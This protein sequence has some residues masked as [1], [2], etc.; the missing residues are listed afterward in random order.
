MEDLTGKIFNGLEVLGFSHKKGKKCYWNL[1]CSCGKLRSPL[2]ADSIKKHT[3]MC[4]CPLEEGLRC[5]KLTYKRHSHTE[6]RRSYCVVVCDCQ[7]EFVTRTDSFK[8][9]RSGCGSC[10]NLYEVVGDEVLLDVST[11]KHPNTFTKIDLQDFDKIKH[12]KWYAVE[13]HCTTYVQASDGKIRIPL[14]R[15]ILGCEDTLVTDHEDGDGLNNTRGNLRQVTR[16]LNNQNLPT[17]H[18]NTSGHI[19][20]SGLDNGKFRS[21][22]TENSVQISLGTFE[23]YQ[24]A[25]DARKSAEIR[26]GFHKNHGR[27]TKES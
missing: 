13:G 17:P 20:V 8:S 1:R 23:N 12:L 5:G 26:Y 6:G 24:D 3:G 22:I 19:G 14:H 4:T 18:N 15:F 25:V 7:K 9:N 2:R 10:P 16:Q 27:K 21:Y 11:E